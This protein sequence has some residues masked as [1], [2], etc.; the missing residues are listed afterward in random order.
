[1]I[2]GDGLV[3][4]MLSLRGASNEKIKEELGWSPTYETC[5]QGFFE[6]LAAVAPPGAN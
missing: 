1:V 5:R 2:A 6:D 4:W 3:T